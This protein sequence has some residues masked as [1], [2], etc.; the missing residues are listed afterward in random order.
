MS[1]Y[2]RFDEAYSVSDLHLSVGDMVDAVSVNGLAS[3]IA[4]LAI[5][6][7]KVAGG[8]AL[9]VNG[10]TVDF[11]SSP[12]AKLFDTKTAPHKLQAIF[13]QNANFWDAVAVFAQAGTVVF[14]LGNHDVE[15][16]LPVCQAMLRKRI[17]HRLVLAFDGAG[18]RCEIGNT[19][20]LF[21]HGNNQDEWNDIDFDRLGRVAAAVNAGRQPERWV[22]NEGTKL[23][24]ELLNEEKQR[25]PFIE[26]VKPEKPWLLT[27]I[28]KLGFG[29]LS[30]QGF[31]LLPRQARASTNGMMR[32]A[33]AESA[34]LG[35]PAQAPSDA[36]LFDA[37]DLL[38]QADMRYRSG[39]RV[40]SGRAPQDAA[41]GFGDLLRSKRAA[42]E[43]IREHILASLEGDATFSPDQSDDIYAA[44]SP[45][46]DRQVH[47]VVCG[48]THLRRSFQD[49]GKR[50]YFNSGT[51]M[52]LIS[53]YEAASQKTQFARVLEAL[54]AK[55][56]EA[57]DAIRWLDEK[58]NTV[59][60][61]VHREPTVVVLQATDSGARGFL[62][63][64]TLDTTE[65]SFTALAGTEREVTP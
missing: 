58:T 21:L 55:S 1:F 41:L 13:E 48:H 39:H 60:A 14:T 3:T 15:L 47:W 51:W 17:G 59:R 32:S 63:E 40:L 65:P 20:A 46:V 25:H 36:T 56:R 6:A 33:R 16:A 9:V 53:L 24:I 28:A 2:E 38:M 61:I 26:F 30:R 4:W 35:V 44:L 34:Y 27:L 7:T 18:Y 19:T 11:L 45:K 22:A 54:D 12:D 42:D 37:G 57:L 64:G 50:A 43:E 29:S 10:D 49:G 5:R 8:A 52:R 23:V 31:R 62:T